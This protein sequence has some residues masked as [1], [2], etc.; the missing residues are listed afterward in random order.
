MF[1]NHNIRKFPLPAFAWCASGKHASSPPT[2]GIS[3]STELVRVVTT[4]SGEL[5]W[6]QQT[7]TIYSTIQYSTV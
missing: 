2:L 3:A 4:A 7:I 1:K 5:Y 6:V